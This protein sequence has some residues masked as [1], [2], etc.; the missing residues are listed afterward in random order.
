LN[1]AKPT[2]GSAPEAPLARRDLRRNCLIVGGGEAGR[3][4]ARDLRRVKAHGL[5]PIG[6]LDDD[7]AKQIV[8]GLPVLGSTHELARVCRERGV[9]VVIVAIPS[10]SP[11]RMRKMVEAGTACGVTVRYLPSFVAALER[12]VRLSD[13]RRISVPGLL[14]RPELNVVRLTS[15]SVVAGKR[16]LVTGAGGSIGSELCRQVKSLE[17]EALYMLDHDETNLHTLQLQLSG[18]GL[19]N[20]EEILIADI[21]DSGRMHQILQSTKPHVVFHVAAHKHL[22]LLELHPGE[23]VK[24]NVMGTANVI[25]AALDAN[26]ERLILISTDKAAD[27]TSVLGATKRLAE[28]LLQTRAGGLTRC[29]SVRFGNVLGSRGSVLS[30][31]AD[32]LVN[33]VAVTVTHPDVTRFFMTIEEAVG[34][35]LEAASMAELAETFVLDMGEPVRIVDLVHNYASQLH[36]DRDH[37]SIRYT[38]LRPGEKLSEALFSEGEERIQT[39]HPRIWATHP[40]KLAPDFA[41]RLAQLF[42]AARQNRPNEEMRERLQGLIPEYS[43]TVHSN[44]KQMAALAA[45]YADDF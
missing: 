23:G 40:A 19:L 35:V 44:V 2:N 4:M 39:P 14:G 13:L 43:R 37:V 45:P 27:P 32:Q 8:A 24:T 11:E 31:I 20:S 9:E 28:M 21:R 29:A 25:D 22:P 12:D 18:H 7:P 17:P 15:A 3:S 30:V 5:L 34:L 6:F 26:V 10:L 36:L 42:E 33:G 1:G 16:V 41:E 38:G